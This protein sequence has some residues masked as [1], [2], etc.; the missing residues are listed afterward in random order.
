MVSIPWWGTNHRRGN[1]DIRTPRHSRPARDQRRG[2][3]GAS[4]NFD[5]YSKS[6]APLKIFKE[7]IIDLMNDSDNDTKDLLADFT[8]W[9]MK[10]LLLTM[11]ELEN[12]IIEKVENTENIQNV[13]LN[14][15]L[16]FSEMFVHNYDPSSSEQ[17]YAGTIDIFVVSN[18]GKKYIFDIKSIGKSTF[19]YQ[20]RNSNFRD[21]L[22]FKKSEENYAVQQSVYKEFIAN[23]FN[24]SVVNEIES[25]I[26]F[27][28]R[29]IDFE[30]D[31]NDINKGKQNLINAVNAITPSNKK[32]QDVK[33]E[34]LKFIND[35]F[36]DT[37]NF[38]DYNIKSLLQSISFQYD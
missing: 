24:E 13:T 18:S 37:S 27:I 25:D 30:W 35:I 21:E 36:D 10:Q 32:E 34:V 28:Q 20:K 12:T 1:E 38:K 16:I 5:S 29:S 33:E 22:L 4:G 3:G 26:T 7:N 17:Q 2:A 14:D 15:L 9:D 19:N 6:G 8:D 31:D 23:I 11:V